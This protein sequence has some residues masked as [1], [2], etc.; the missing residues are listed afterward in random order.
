MHIIASLLRHNHLASV[1]FLTSFLSVP[2]KSFYRL[3]QHDGR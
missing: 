2:V 1:T 3:L